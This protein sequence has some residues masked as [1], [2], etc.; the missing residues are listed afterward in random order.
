M[1][2]ETKKKIKSWVDFALNIIKVV[3]LFLGID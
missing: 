3:L 1:T 2:D